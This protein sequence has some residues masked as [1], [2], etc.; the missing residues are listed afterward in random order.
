MADSFK[1]IQEELERYIAGI[2]RLAPTKTFGGISLEDLKADRATLQAKDEKV[3]QDEATLED[4]RVDRKNFYKAQE[5]RLELVKNGVI[6]D[7]EFG[8]DSAL[9]GS[10]GFKRKS[11]YD[12][13]LTRDHKEDE[14]K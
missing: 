8:P 1:D 14:E 7:T 12:S 6:G 11:E 9:I 13:G 10:M 3:E 5:K 2:S 4:S